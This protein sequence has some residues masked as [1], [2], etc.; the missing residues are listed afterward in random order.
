M[1]RKKTSLLQ[2]PDAFD[3]IEQWFHPD[4]PDELDRRL[5]LAIDALQSMDPSDW[6]AAMEDSLTTGI[7]SDAMDHFFTHWLGDG[8]FWPSIAGSTIA[9]KMHAAY[10]DAFED[11]RDR[12]VP[13][14]WLWVTPFAG[15]DAFE[16]FAAKN[17]NAVVITFVTSTPADPEAD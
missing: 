14:T 3:A 7:D 9:E 6:S 1:L 11:A 17:A 10:L 12:N 5:S 16:A 13:V 15:A 4:D 8:G 2:G